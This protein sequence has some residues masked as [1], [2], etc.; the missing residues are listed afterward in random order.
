MKIRNKKRGKSAV[1]RKKQ[2]EGDD[3]QRE[4]ETEV[5]RNKQKVLKKKEK[6]L[7]TLNQIEFNL[8]VSSKMKSIETRLLTGEILLIIA[9]TLQLYVH[10]YIVIVRAI[11]N[12]QSRKK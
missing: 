2:K 7:H 9:S 3:R 6:G 11:Y 5:A 1:N 8:H 10:I 4:E 12:E